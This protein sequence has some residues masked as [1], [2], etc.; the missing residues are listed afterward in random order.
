MKLLKK[1]NF[2][3]GCIG[4]ACRMFTATGAPT[5]FTKFRHLHERV[6]RAQ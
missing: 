5:G 4:I 1:D 3:H 2:T 6:D